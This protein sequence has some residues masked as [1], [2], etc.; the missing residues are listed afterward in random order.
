MMR[1]LARFLEPLARR[2]TPPFSDVDSLIE[3][4]LVLRCKFA[5]TE[6]EQIPDYFW[7][8]TGKWKMRGMYSAHERQLSF[9]DR[10]V[11][12]I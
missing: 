8:V 1:Q 4:I 3:P 6:Q 7:P 5:D 2:F 11:N 12:L 10:C 9:L